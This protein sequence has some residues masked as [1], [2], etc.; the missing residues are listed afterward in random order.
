MNVSG[1]GR[2][3]GMPRDK[4]C[5]GLCLRAAADGFW[6]GLSSSHEVGSAA[7]SRLTEAN[8]TCAEPRCLTR[9]LIPVIIDRVTNKVEMQ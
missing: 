7:I 9:S 6:T 4:Q 5:G 8:D 2:Q 1:D 3:R